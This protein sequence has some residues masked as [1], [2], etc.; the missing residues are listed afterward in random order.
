[1]QPLGVPQTEPRAER[2]GMCAGSRREAPCAPLPPGRAR[3]P[4]CGHLCVPRCRGFGLAS[5]LLSGGALGDSASNSSLRAGPEG[6]LRP[7]VGPA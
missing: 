4:V 3:S 5:L 1:M 6:S 2:P 7:R